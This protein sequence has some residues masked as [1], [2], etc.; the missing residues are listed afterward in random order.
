MKTWI[1]TL[2]FVLALSGAVAIAGAI[3]TW[4]SG[5]VLTS[6]DLN[7]TFAHIH[8]TMVGGHGARMVDADVSASA[9]ITHSKMATPA[10][11]P[12]A[13]AM[14][15]SACVATPCTILAGSGISGITRSSAGS[16]VITWSVA[17]ADANYGV[18]CTA[19]GFPNVCTLTAL[20]TT[21]STMGTS[22]GGV[23]TDSGFT[24]MM[25]DNL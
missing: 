6:S 23:L 24:V 22:I 16:Y 11:L 12:K 10:L 19:I 4:G 25:M 2:T 20:T 8:N 15:G 14:V 3:K 7:A 13:W 17:R 1:K 9:A 21:T 18:L 5:E